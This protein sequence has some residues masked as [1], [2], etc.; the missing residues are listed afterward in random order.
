MVKNSKT[1]GQSNFVVKLFHRDGEVTEEAL[2]YSLV[3]SRDMF[4]LPSFIYIRLS[5][6]GSQI[7]KE[8]IGNGQNLE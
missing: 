3:S 8:F 5:S 1:A 6:H 4:I 7:V 2:F